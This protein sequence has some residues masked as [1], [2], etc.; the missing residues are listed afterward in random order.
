[1]IE[2]QVEINSITIAWGQRKPKLDQIEY[3]D[4]IIWWTTTS[5]WY[6]KLDYFDFEKWP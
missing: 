3:G 1:L 6:G 5:R 2:N 4:D